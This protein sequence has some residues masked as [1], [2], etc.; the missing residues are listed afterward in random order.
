MSRKA[1]WSLKPQVKGIKMTNWTDNPR[2][3]THIKKKKP[4][5]STTPTTSIT[6]KK[7]FPILYGSNDVIA[8]YHKP[9]L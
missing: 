2:P 3:K 5:K 4:N 8:F 1:R 6:T 9:C 7:V